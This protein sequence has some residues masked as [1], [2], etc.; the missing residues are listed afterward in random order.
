MANEKTLSRELE[1]NRAQSTQW[2]DRAR[3]AV[4]SGDDELARK[5]L[6]RKNEH[7]KLVA[8]LED[9][10]QAAGEAS[11][12][13]Q[14]QLAGMKAKL[15]EAKR[16]LATLSARKRAADFRKKIDTQAAGLSSQVD[17]SAFEKFDR[18]KAKVEQ[19]EAE[20]E[21]MAELR[22]KTCGATSEECGEAPEEEAGDFDVAAELAD[23]KRKL[24]K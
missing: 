14:R 6:A 2:Q 12:A 3:K 18:L 10:S 8:A 16:N 1:R 17:E 4:E 9:Q 15:A 7:E 13:L 11:S 5:A 20:A 22:A 24:K 23:L 19:A 21:A